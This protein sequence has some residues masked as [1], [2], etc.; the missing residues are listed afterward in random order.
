MAIHSHADTPA[1]GNHRNVVWKLARRKRTS[2]PN[3][4]PQPISRSVHIWNQQWG[5]PRCCPCNASVRRRSD[6]RLRIPYRFY[7]CT[8]SRIRRC[9][10]SNGSP[11]IIR[12]KGEKQR[13]AANYRHND[14]LHSVVGNIL[15]QLL[16]NRRRR[17][18]IHGVGSGQ[19]RRGIHEQHSHIHRSYCHRSCMLAHACQATQHAVAWR[20]IR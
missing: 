12:D 5:Q 2:A 19:F 3:S 9:I 18:L 4:L 16:R 7:G 15:T 17:P 8:D 20:A 13:Y 1:T 14:R 11:I 10:R 6:C